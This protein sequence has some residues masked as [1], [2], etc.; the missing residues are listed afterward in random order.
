MRERGANE[1]A[2]NGFLAK[3]DEAERYDQA[4]AEK[5]VE[6]MLEGADYDRYSPDNFAE[7]LRELT[8]E[9][10]T[11][12]AKAFRAANSGDSDEAFAILNAAIDDYWNGQAFVAAQAI[13]DLRAS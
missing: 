9:Q 3:Q 8:D 6:L 11:Q 13:V 2:L 4:V 1:D 10:T 7:A 12:I 5:T